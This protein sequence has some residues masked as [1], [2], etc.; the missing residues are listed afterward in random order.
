MKGTIVSAWMNT[1][2][3]MY[4]KEI[5]SDV[6][7]SY[8]L[9]A[10][11]MFT[12]TEEVEDRIALGM[13]EAIGKKVDKGP[14]E[15]W[16]TM[17]HQNVKTYSQIY[18][19]F[20]KYDNLY[21]FLQAM[22]DIHVIVTQ[23]FKGAKPPILHI[24]A[25]DTYNARMTY[26]SPRGMFSYFIG[27]LEGAS[28]Y[29]NEKV[30]VET[31]T[32]TSDFLEINIQF[33]HPITIQKSFIFNKVLTLGF[34]KKLETKLA[35]AMV[36]FV[37]IPAALSVSYLPTN[38]AI[39][40]II[41]LT[42]SMPLLISKQ[43]FKP[44][45]HINR[46]LD[47]LKEKDFS[48][49]HQISTDDIFEELNGKLMA[50]IGGIKSDFVGYKSTTDELNV[51]AESF[52]HI[53]ENMRDTSKDIAAIVDQVADGAV[54]QATETHFVSSQINDSI[55]TLNRVVEKENQGKNALEKSVAVIKGGFEEME[56]TTHHLNDT[57]VQF[58][59]FKQKGEALQQNVREVR[60]IVEVV[61]GIAGQTNLLALNAAIEAERVG[62]QGK[63]FAVVATEI[64]KLSQGS[65]TAVLSINNQLEQFI[66]NIEDFMDG[67]TTQF[68]VIETENN[69]LN[70][71]TKENAGSVESVVAVSNLIVELIDNLITETEQFNL[72]SETITSL[73]SIAEENSASTEEVSASVLSYTEEIEAMSNHIHEFKR[74]SSAFSEDLE[75]YKI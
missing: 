6:M 34:I 20:F 45:T 47:T 8:G 2:K 28:I 26:R 1:C 9:K 37:G 30:N 73:A 11:K 50:L 57:L 38:I 63:G 55:E 71:I 48:I 7:T 72:M 23:K 51:F 60:K 54:S 61:E 19:A 74:V 36:L 56:R 33:Q 32:R 16:R 49:A 24:E 31:I 35:L 69:N 5:V 4:G 22:Y 58:S 21:S 67:I 3:E 53:S 29:Y 70:T 68:A 18:P 40:S 12:P 65:R 27:M 46:Y 52:A 43:L 17:A 44:I 41:I 10:N 15:M 39:L 64:R 66:A 13:V 59:T 42:V 75:K 62:E 25:V 14:D